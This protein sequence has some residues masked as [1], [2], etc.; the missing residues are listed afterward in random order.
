MVNN[1]VKMVHINDD[2]SYKISLKFFFT[3]RGAL[4][5]RQI[6]FVKKIH[7]DVT[8]ELASLPECSKQF[9]LS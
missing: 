3:T 6:F 4:T 5:K 1:E 9:E 7:Y 2:F 8:R